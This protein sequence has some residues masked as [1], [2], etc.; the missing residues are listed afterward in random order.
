V[1]L[2]ECHLNQNAR[3]RG[4]ARYPAI[5]RQL[6]DLLQRSDVGLVQIPCPEVHCL[7]PHR[8]RPKGVTLRE[9]METPQSRSRCRELARETA[10]RID[11]LT[12]RGV[13]VVAILGGDVAS[14]GCAVHDDPAGGLSPRS[15]VFMQELD[16]ELRSRSSKIAFRGIRESRP[17]AF[18]ADLQWI[19][20]RLG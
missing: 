5:N 11:G 1:V 14:P 17:E 3:D 12:H 9:A 18:A 2:I 19:S 16:A 4:A 20:E 7:G 8:A 6:L 15:G 10:D 13:E